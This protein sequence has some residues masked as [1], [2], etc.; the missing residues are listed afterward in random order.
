MLKKGGIVQ[1]NTFFVKQ[2]QVNNNLVNI[3]DD[4][5]HHIKHVLRLKINEKAY[6]CDDKSNK[7]LAKLV[8]YEENKA[9]FEIE[10]QVMQSSETSVNI[11]LF[12]GFPKKDKLELIIQKATELG[13]K[14]IFPVVMDT[15]ISK[16]DMNKD[17]SKLERWQKIA[18]EAS[19][20][21]W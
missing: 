13:V 15:S 1:L 7:F 5:F 14:A 20:S 18:N 6:I 10:E 3:S 16:F 2:T 17:S 9:V 8:K 19:R 11:T 12:Q 4:D 21:V